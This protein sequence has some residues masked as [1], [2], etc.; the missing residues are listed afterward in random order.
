MRKGN[1]IVRFSSAYHPNMNGFVERAFGSTNAL[2]RSMLAAAGLPDPYWEK[3]S[4]HAVLMRCIMPNQTATGFVREAYYLWYGLTYDYSRL[5]TWGCRAYALN[6]QREKDYGHRSIAGI[7]VGMKPENPVTC[8]YEI[9][10]PAKDIFVTTGDVVFCCLGTTIKTAGSEKA[11]RRVDF[12]LVRW[13][14]VAANENGI[15]RFLVVSSMGA[16]ADSKNFYL[17]TKGE[18]EK[19]I[20]ALNFEKCIIARPSMLLGPRK[21]F[22]MGEKIGQ[23]FMLAFG[24][25]IPARYK[26][27]QALTVAKAL[28]STAFDANSFGV[29]ENDALRKYR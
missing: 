6:H 11:F 14:A 8:D 13:A 3:A 2:A 17:R 9:Y 26:A 15:K 24:L 18:M 20:T 5:R 27:I 28:Q 7:F 21:E 1:S 10:L 22:R 16:N 12:E 25:F 4:R 23:F 19:A 29:L